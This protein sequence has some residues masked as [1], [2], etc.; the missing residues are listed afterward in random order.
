MQV[1]KQ[2]NEHENTTMF[3]V[4]KE[5]NAIFP[6]PLLETEDAKFWEVKKLIVNA[7]KNSV[8][9]RYKAAKRNLKTKIDSKIRRIYA[10]VRTKVDHVFIGIEQQ[11]ANATSS[12]QTRNI[13]TSGLT[14]KALDVQTIIQE[15]IK[16]SVS[17]MTESTIRGIR[18]LFMVLFFYGLLGTLS[19]AYLVI[20]TF[21]YVF[22]RVTISEKNKVFATLNT[23][24]KELP[25]GSI[26][27]CGDTYTIPA[28]SQEIYYVS[29]SFEPSG[30]P[31]KFVVPYPKTSILPRI[32]SQIYSMNRIKMRNESPIQFRAIG[33]CEF[34][35]WTIAEGEEVVFNYQ[36]LVALT[37]TVRMKSVLNLRVTT[38][39]LGK[40][41]HKVAVGPG[42]IILMSKGRPIISG[43]E[44]ANT[45]LAQNRILAWNGGTR[46]D[47]D[48]EL[49][50]VDIYLS[51]FY[52][53]KM[54]EDLI[55]IDADAKGKA[56]SGLIQYVKGLVWPF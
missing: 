39:I 37:S 51:G 40:L 32:K 23:S 44:S 7:M 5:F 38:L 54:N 15:S 34:I 53:K 31:P 10:E 43:E 30:M 33:S 19:F 41:F 18:I 21:M 48:S 42:K 56:S 12:Y 14:S 13:D 49:N 47:I 4:D 29:R 50:L 1:F 25:Q 17:E 2:I 52:L 22:A 55:V 16:G 11:Y 3:T 20:Q 9:Q 28:N 46:F 27:A 36:N 35:E 24:M 6:E 26:K 45:S 8:N